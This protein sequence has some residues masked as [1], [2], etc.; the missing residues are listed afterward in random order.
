MHKPNAQT[1]QFESQ[2]TGSL[3]MSLDHSDT[4]LELAQLNKS[5]SELF[6]TSV[7]NDQ[8]GKA[9]QALDSDIEKIIQKRADL[10]ESLL[11]SLQEQQKISFARKEI[12]INQV[13]LEAVELKRKNV[14]ENLANIS[15]ASRAIK[16]Y[17]QV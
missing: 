12:N 6:N 7:E 3:S 11:S 14:R 9:Y 2:T 15:K 17:H 16:E 8:D 4:P 13:L 1:S 10:V 5:I